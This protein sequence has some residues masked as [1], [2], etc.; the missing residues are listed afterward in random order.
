MP[1]VETINCPKCLKRISLDLRTI[2]MLN[3]MPNATL[4]VGKTP[5]C[6]SCGASVSIDHFKK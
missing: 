4:H 1:Y 5:T 6:P 2:Q 3:M